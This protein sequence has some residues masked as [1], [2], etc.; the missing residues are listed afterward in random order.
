VIFVAF[1]DFVPLPSA[2]LSRERY[3][4]FVLDQ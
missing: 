3:V 1:V 2:R 4:A